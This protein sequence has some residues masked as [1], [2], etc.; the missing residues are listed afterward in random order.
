MWRRRRAS[1]RNPALLAK[2]SPLTNRIRRHFAGI[3]AVRRA[4]GQSWLPRQIE[5]GAEPRSRQG[6]GGAPGAQGFEDESRGLARQ[7]RQSGD[8]QRTLRTFR[9]RNSGH[10][11]DESQETSKRTLRKRRDR[12]PERPCRPPCRC[13]PRRGHANGGPFR[14]RSPARRCDRPSGP[15]A[16]HG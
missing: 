6:R 1:R 4:R 5:G 10:F 3:K 9:I 14:P 2:K 13:R 8:V 11:E 7:R 16:P 12:R 15:S